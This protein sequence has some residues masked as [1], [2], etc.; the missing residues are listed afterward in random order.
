MLLRRK[1]V[2]LGVLVSS[3]AG[4]SNAFGGGFVSQAPITAVT[5][6]DYGGTG[7]FFVSVNQPVAGAPSCATQPMKFVIN[8]STDAGRAQISTVL[9]AQSAGRLI[10]ILGTGTCDVWGDTETVFWVQS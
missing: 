10:S 9:A 7:Q 5:A 4:F 3:V 6:Q 8:A 1:I 2:V